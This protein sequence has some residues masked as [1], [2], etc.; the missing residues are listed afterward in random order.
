MNIS[1]GHKIK[2]SAKELY[3]TNEK[4]KKRLFDS[5]KLCLILDL[6]HTLLH[7][8]TL[9]NEEVEEGVLEIESNRERLG[10]KLRPDLKNFLDSLKNKFEFSVYTQ[11]TR[12]YAEKVCKLFDEEGDYFQNRILTRSDET[13]DNTTKQLSN[14]FPVSE[15][16]VFILDDRSDVWKNNGDANLV[17]IK[18]YKYFHNLRE[19]N[20]S[21]GREFSSSSKQDRE[22]SFLKSFFVKCHDLFYESRIYDA[23]KIL[24][25]LRRSILNQIKLAVFFDEPFLRKKCFS[26]GCLKVT[27]I[28]NFKE[29]KKFTHLIVEKK[30]S[31]K[32]KEDVKFRQELFQWSFEKNIWLLDKNW[33]FSCEQSWRRVEEEQ[34][35]VVKLNEMQILLLKGNNG[36]EEE[37]DSDDSFAAELE[38]MDD[39]EPQENGN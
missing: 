2:L 24:L 36:A 9:G 16:M 4:K 20:N 33:I 21:S 31:K 15:N 39:R 30:L 28:D 1:G 7:A 27:I 6:D 38:D 14:L 18:P 22:L 19:I 26:L 12:D 5:K 35:S 8:K 11:G 34:F 23:R 3:S 17:T 32:I 13:K 25:Q 10:V 37:S 29:E